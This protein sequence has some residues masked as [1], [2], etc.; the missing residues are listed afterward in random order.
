[1]TTVI[2]APE[3]I[4][5]AVAES[6]TVTFDFSNILASAETIASAEEITQSNTKSATDLTLG[7]P[8]INSGEITVD[9]VTIAIGKAVQLLVSVGQ[10]LI[11]YTLVSEVVTSAP[12]T[13]VL[14]TDLLVSNT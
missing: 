12:H 11:H 7:S 5:K 6:L 9:G 3:T 2:T 1:M 13:R 14:N 8:S 4:V 10:N